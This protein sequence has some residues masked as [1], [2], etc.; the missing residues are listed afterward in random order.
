METETRTCRRIVAG[1]T[2]LGKKIATKN[3][4]RISNKQSVWLGTQKSPYTVG[5]VKAHMYRVCPLTSKYISPVDRLMDNPHYTPKKVANQPTKRNIDALQETNQSLKE[6]RLIWFGIQ[7]IFVRRRYTV[8]SRLNYDRVQRPTQK[9]HSCIQRYETKVRNCEARL[10]N[11]G[12]RLSNNEKPVVLLYYFKSFN[13]DR[14]PPEPVQNRLIIIVI[15]LTD[16][17]QQ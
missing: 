5:Q 2:A 4:R 12:K 15:C 10:R 14:T 13:A 7:R 11:C 3:F 9:C 16:L 17:S 6:I 8:T 1:E